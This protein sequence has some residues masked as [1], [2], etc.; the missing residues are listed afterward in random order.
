MRRTRR[1]HPVHGRLRDGGGYRFIDVEVVAFQAL[2]GRPLA[3]MRVGPGDLRKTE[4]VIERPVFQHQHEEVLDPALAEF[5]PGRVVR[6]F[7]RVRFLERRGVSLVVGKIHR[8]M[9]AVDN[10]AGSLRPRLRH[11]DRDRIAVDR[12]DRTENAATRPLTIE[13]DHRRDRRHFRPGRVVRPF[14][15]V[16]RLQR[17]GVGG[18]VVRE[19][20]RNARAVQDRSRSR[21]AVIRRH[22]DRERVAGSGDERA[23]HA[24][25]GP[26]AI[27]IDHGLNR[28]RGRNRVGRVVVRIGAAA[29]RGIRAMMLHGLREF[30]AGRG[31]LNEVLGFEDPYAGG[32]QSIAIRKQE[33]ANPRGPHDHG[34]TD[35]RRA[36]ERHHRD[37]KSRGDANLR[38]CFL[39][40]GDCLVDRVESGLN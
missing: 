31:L 19:F 26:R 36:G 16:W 37:A 22:V 39:I 7:D 4:H 35:K 38:C 28:R 10:G 30:F 15:Q 33:R 23:G 14:D 24:A 17:P 21:G 6:P 9:R 34:Q 27:E 11:V 29:M 3:G 12:D 20:Y 32:N 18:L 25:A 2:S 13:I 40:V 1:R 5:R 8:D